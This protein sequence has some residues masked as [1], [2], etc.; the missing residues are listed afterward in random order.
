MPRTITRTANAIKNDMDQPLEVAAGGLAVATGVPAASDEEELVIA[1][2]VAA[3]V[4]SG[5]T[6]VSEDEL[7]LTSG[8]GVTA[9]G[10]SDRLRASAAGGLTVSEGVPT[11]AAGVMTVSTAGAGVA[12][13]V[14]TVSADGVSAAAGVMTFSATM[15]AVAAGATADAGDVLPV[16][17]GV[18]AVA[19]GAAPFAGAQCSEIIFTAVTAKLL[20]EPELAAVVPCPETSMSW[21]TCGFRSTI[22]P[23]I[24]NVRVVPS[25]ATV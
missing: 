8:A 1:V 11:V 6:V 5:V 25:S 22:L 4:V 19:R 15:L 2:G 21:P 10:V 14:R 23:V 12:A 9:A 24:V 3:A 17:D 13:A 18:W 16:S 20:G 7:T